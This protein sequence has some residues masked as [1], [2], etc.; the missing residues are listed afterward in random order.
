VTTRTFGYASRSASSAPAPEKPNA[1]AFSFVS[2]AS[3]SK[4]SIAIS[5][6]GPRNAAAVSSSA[7]GAATSENSS[8]T[9]S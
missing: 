6:H 5:R 1:A 7:A 4:P 8:F 3:H 9:G 2:G